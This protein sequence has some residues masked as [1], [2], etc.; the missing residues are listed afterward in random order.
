MFKFKPLLGFCDTLYFLQCWR[1]NKIRALCKHLVKLGVGTV[2]FDNKVCRRNQGCQ[3]VCFQTKI[4]I[5][6]NFGEGLTLENVGIH[7][8]I[9]YGHLVGLFYGDL[10]CLGPFGTLCVHLKHLFRFWYH[11]PRTI[12]QPWAKRHSANHESTKESR[13][14]TTSSRFSAVSKNPQVSLEKWFHAEGRGQLLF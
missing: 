11:V 8:Y 7:M 1:C 3:M 4:P 13:A 5:W 10:G 2:R 14:K 12:W 6:V 9:C